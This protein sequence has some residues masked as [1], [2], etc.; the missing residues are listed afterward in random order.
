MLLQTRVSLPEEPYK[1]NKV[2]ISANISLHNEENIGAALLTKSA[3][4]IENGEV[5]INDKGL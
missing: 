4:E 1:D 3:T 5:K 2:N